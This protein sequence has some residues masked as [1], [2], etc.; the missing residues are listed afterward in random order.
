MSDDYEP[1]NPNDESLIYTPCGGSREVEIT[2]EGVYDDA[3]TF[4]YGWETVNGNKWNLGDIDYGPGAPEYLYWPIAEGENVLTG[5][6][7]GEKAVDTVKIELRCSWGCIVLDYEPLRYNLAQFLF[8]AWE[9]DDKENFEYI[10]YTHTCNGYPAPTVLEIDLPEGANYGVPCGETLQIAATVSGEYGGYSEFLY[11]WAVFAEVS[12]STVEIA[13]GKE[14]E[15]GEELDTGKPVESD[16]VF[17]V[18]CTSACE[19]SGLTSDEAELSFQASQGLAFPSDQQSWTAE[20]TLFATRKF[21][22]KCIDLTCT[23]GCEK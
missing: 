14:I 5:G 10:Y 19:I 9:G 12:G 2:I 1:T 8:K 20:Q 4:K 21:L 22:V 17:E 15:I 11:K 6:V 7:P 23:N 16:V 13:S 3:G 18:E